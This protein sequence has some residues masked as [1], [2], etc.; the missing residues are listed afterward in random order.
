MP[1]AEEL[2]RIE[3]STLRE[4]GS[5]KWSLGENKTGAFIAEMDFGMAPPVRE[6]LHQAV[7]AGLSGYLPSWLVGQM[8]RA[9]TG[10]AEQHYGWQLDPVQVRP[11]ADVLQALS[12]T[13]ELFTP[14]GAAIVLPTPAYMPFLTLPGAHGRRIIQVP[15]IPGEAGYRYDL[16]ALDA[17]FADGGGLLVLCNPHNPIGRV[18]STAEMAEISDVVARHDARV[19]AD[20]IH[21]P[22]V[23]SPARHVPY[24]SI[25]AQ[26]ARQAITATST[27][28][29]WNLPGM[30]CAQVILSNEEDR[31]RWAER[32][33]E[34]EK[35][36][37]T[38]GV[39]AAQA[40]YTEGEPWLQDV[41]TYLDSARG[42][43]AD[44]VAEHLPQVDYRPPEGTYLGWLDVRRWGLADPGAFFAREAGVVT[45]DG[46][47]CGTAGQR[48]L[49]YNFATPRPVMA[50]SI[51]AMGAALAEG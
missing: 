15:M 36:A 32:A 39:V 21:A 11:I 12:A 19:F 45:V 29:A 46:S 48:F 20:E 37:S 43:L 49:R 1:T 28:K 44:L 16:Q 25:S 34:Y 14:P 50:R 3:E 7:E 40:A 41:L 18:L 23:Y 33:G 5:V 31:T 51:A 26:A 27:S 30:K 2:D 35:S 24:A 22:L 42:L 10:W 6:A 38:L 9:Y 47:L 4:I 13:I 17:A 8:Q